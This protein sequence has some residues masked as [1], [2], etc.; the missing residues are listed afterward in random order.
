MPKLVIPM[1]LVLVPK[2]QS[3]LPEV[4]TLFAVAVSQ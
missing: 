1:S 2:S 3:V 4:K